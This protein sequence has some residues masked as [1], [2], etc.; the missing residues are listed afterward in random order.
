MATEKNE[1]FQH[2]KKF[3]VHQ[4][5]KPMTYYNRQ[6]CPLELQS[7]SCQQNLPLKIKSMVISTSL[8]I[9]GIV[10]INALFQYFIMNYSSS[11]MNEDNLLKGVF[12]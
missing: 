8:C 10:K 7:S 6:T 3:K 11:R 2:F 5:R 4:S 12:V 9:D 1:I